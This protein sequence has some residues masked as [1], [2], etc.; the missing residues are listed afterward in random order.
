MSLV[1]EAGTE[2]IAPMT[3]LGHASYRLS[4][5]SVSICPE[6]L[7]V[8]VLTSHPSVTSESSSELN[9]TA[10]P[11]L[12][13]TCELNRSSDI[14]ATVS[15]VAE[16]VAFLGPG[17]TVSRRAARRRSRRNRERTIVSSLARHVAY[18]RYSASYRASTTY[19]GVNAG[20]PARTLVRGAPKCH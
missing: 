4:G 8:S 10:P 14:D 5:V 2:R 20:A 16:N 18:V 7:S 13:R 12:P 3:T 15:D 17:F 9:A 1:S 19:A 6:L 11:R